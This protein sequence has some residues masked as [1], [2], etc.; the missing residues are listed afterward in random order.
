MI[1][2]FLIVL[3]CTELKIKAWCYVKLLSNNLVHFAVILLMKPFTSGIYMSSLIYLVQYL[4]MLSQAH[5][6]F[7]ILRKWIG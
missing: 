5:F 6:S 2:S 1:L 4:A 7:F 3:F